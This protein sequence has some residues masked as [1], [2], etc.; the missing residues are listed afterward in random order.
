MPIL[1]LIWLAVGIGLAWLVSQR[2]IHE[3]RTFSRPPATHLAPLLRVLQKSVQLRKRIAM[4]G[5]SYADRLMTMLRL[6]GAG[7]LSRA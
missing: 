7:D 1:L 5:N 3:L 4:G 6:S 2:P